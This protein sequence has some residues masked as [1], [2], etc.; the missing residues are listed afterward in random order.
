MRTFVDEVGLD[1]ILTQLINRGWANQRNENGVI[2]F[3]LTDAGR[4]HHSTVLIAQK[5]VRQRAMHGVSDEE[6]MMVIHVLQR[7]VNN[8]GA[9]SATS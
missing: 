5:A 3:Q 6:Y 7:I 2:L 8:L 4:H 9:D 1:T